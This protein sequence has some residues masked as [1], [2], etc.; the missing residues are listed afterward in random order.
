MA[1][2][3]SLNLAGLAFANKSVTW[4]DQ[5]VLTGL[6]GNNASVTISSEYNFLIGSAGSTSAYGT[7]SGRL[8]KSRT[9][10]SISASG[11]TIHYMG[12]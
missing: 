1:D 10:G 7:T 9:N 2:I 6:S 8:V 3:N 11:T 4:K 12:N 5:Y